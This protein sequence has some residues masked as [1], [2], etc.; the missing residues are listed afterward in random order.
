MPVRHALR[1]QD[2][3]RDGLNQAAF[4]A[5]DNDLHAGFGIEVHMHARDDL[6]EELVLDAVEFVAHIARVM[7]EHD[8]ERAHDLFAG[9]G[10]FFLD[11]RVAH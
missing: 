5:Q 8:G 6:L 7:V 2:D 10:A 9:H 11:E 4:A 3:I 1:A